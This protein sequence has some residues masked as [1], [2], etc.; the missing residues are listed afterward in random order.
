VSCRSVNEVVEWPVDAIIPDNTLKSLAEAIYPGINDPNAPLPTA[1]YL[2]G[3]ALLAA[4]NDTVDTL[5]QTLLNIMPGE[6]F[7]SLSA[8]NITLDD[9]RNM[10]DRVS[11]RN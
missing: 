11:Q 8:D 10:C 9:P 4:R 1:Q 3:R 2:A 6:Q 5:N 7:I